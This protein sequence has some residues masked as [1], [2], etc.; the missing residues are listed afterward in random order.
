MSKNH[1][2]TIILFA[3]IAR[4]YKEELPHNDVIWEMFA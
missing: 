1:G 3:G 2:K 4:C